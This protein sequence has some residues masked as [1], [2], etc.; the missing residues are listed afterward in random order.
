MIIFKVGNT[1]IKGITMQVAYFF[2]IQGELGIMS[3]NQTQGHVSLRKNS[4]M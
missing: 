4:N 1:H 3:I 2:I